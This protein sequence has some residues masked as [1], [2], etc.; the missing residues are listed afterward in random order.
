MSSEEKKENGTIL[1]NESYFSDF[2]RL[3]PNRIAVKYDE[4]K[5]DFTY[6]SLEMMT[7]LAKVREFGSKKYSRDNW[8][9]GFKIARSL[10]ATLRHVFA[11]LAGQKYDPES[12][13]DH[14]WHAACS[15]EH[16]I[17]DAANH[18]QNEINPIVDNTEDG[19]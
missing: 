2:P 19:R 12:G 6:V 3:E 18:P 4:G 11:R 14:L 16:A 17:Y 8:K 1:I 7:A 15:L 5:P 10:A 13:L 9:N